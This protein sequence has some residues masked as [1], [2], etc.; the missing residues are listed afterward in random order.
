MSI[1]RKILS[2]LWKAFMYGKD[3]TLPFRGERWK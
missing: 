3:E 2:I 1:L